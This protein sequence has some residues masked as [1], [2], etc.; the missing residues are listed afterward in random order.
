MSDRDKSLFSEDFNINK[1]DKK[2]DG[3]GIYNVSN[4]PNVKGDGITDD[5]IAIQAI[6]DEVALKGGGI[7]SFERKTYKAKLTFKQGVSL[8]GN[9]C[10]FKPTSA[11]GEVIKFDSYISH[12][13][14]KYFSIIGNQTYTDVTQHGIY[15]P[16]VAN[17]TSNTLAGLNDCTFEH[18]IIRYVGGNGLYLEGGNYYSVIQFNRF[19]NILIQSNGQHGI[20][21][22]GQIQS[23]K[24]ERIWIRD[25]VLNGM[26]TNAYLEGVTWYNTNHNTY[27]NCNFEENLREGLYTRGNNNYYLSCW[28]EGNSR[29]DLTYSCGVYV[30]SI[31][32]KSSERFEGCHFAQH[33][34]DIWL[35]KGNEVLID[36]TSFAWNNVPNT[37]ASAISI[38]TNSH[39]NDFGRLEFSIDN[40]AV[41]NYIVSQGTYRIKRINASGSVTVPTNAGFID[42]TLET[43]EITTP[44]PVPTPTWNAGAV[45]VSNLTRTSFRINFST[46]P[47]TDSTCYYTLN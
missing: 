22:D 40:V 12:C 9:F 2:N 30:N 35:F 44:R 11:S 34:R 10:T 17:A 43:S 8:N 1:L 28:F 47:T 15:L 26:K 24:F 13:F 33:N 38:E 5:S 20:Y 27:I 29:N 16:R 23:N 14:Y 37:K 25:N 3:Y 32:T 39:L 18:I 19:Q 46:V 21:C 6:I 31:F 42:V 36:K 45:W 41:P 7:I 4:Y